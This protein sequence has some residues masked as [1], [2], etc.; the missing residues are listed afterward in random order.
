MDLVRLIRI[1]S[2]RVKLLILVPLFAVLITFLLT[3]KMENVYK[4]S[5]QIAA[6]IV[7]ESKISIEDKADLQSSFLIQTKFSNIIELIK[8]KQVM[9]QVSMRLLLH[10]LVDPTPFRKPSKLFSGMDDQARAN[11]KKLLTDKLDSQQS[12]SAYNPAEVGMVKLVKSMGYDDVSMSKKLKVERLGTSDFIEISFEAESAELSSFV[13][14]TVCGEFLRFYKTVKMQQNNN[15]VD[16][17]ERLARQ[18]KIELDSVV[19][20]LK[21]FKLQHQIIN[22]YEQ[23]KSLV[24]QISS[25]E[26][27]READNK[28]IPA[29]QAAIDEIDSKFSSK[30]KS[31]IE[32]KLEPYQKKVTDIKRRIEDVNERYISSGFSNETLRDSLNMLRGEMNSS[33]QSISDNFILDPNVSRQELVTKKISYE[34][35]LEIAKKSVVSMDKERKR[36]Q[37]IVETFTPCDPAIGS[38]DREISVLAE[39]YLVILNKLTLAKFASEASGQGI[40]ITEGAITPDL[41]EA[42]KRMLLIIISA[43]V[44]F[45]LC[46]VLILVFEY[47][48]LTVKTPRQFVKLSGLDLLGYLNLLEKQALDL[49]ELFFSKKSEPEYRVFK[50]LL[51]ATRLELSDTLHGKKIVLITGTN[52]GEGKSLIMLSLAYSFKLTGLKVLLVDTNFKNPS[53]T[54]QFKAKPLLESALQG[55]VSLDEAITKTSIADIDILGCDGAVGTPDEIA[56]KA[57]LPEFLAN[58]TS[59]YDMVFLEGPSLSKYSDSKEWMHVVD[60]AVIIFSA[61]RTIEQADKD[62]FAFLKTLD[63]KFAGA[64]LNKVSPENIEQSYGEIPKDR[65]KFRILVKQILK[66]NFSKK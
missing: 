24:N 7:D 11:A 60:K 28:Q 8:C 26:L 49:N 14:N 23:T 47:L 17:W 30:Q 40:R 44:S 32:A 63:D 1:L 39:A 38:Y 29:L 65:T 66:R 45:I 10:D 50:N 34:C 3:L 19:E 9:D 54:K 42:S 33:V 20:V 62:V 59:G 55:K 57:A 48:D 37:K 41:P 43:L 16:F 4:S 5:A 64:I 52:N 51:Q 21:N 46:I 18:K 15:S 35:D 12:F 58:L 53:L 2:K 13:P 56:G 22:L 6:G 25:L 36:L 31:Y 27:Q 61:N